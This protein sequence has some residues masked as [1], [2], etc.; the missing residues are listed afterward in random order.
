[1]K[2]FNERGQLQLG[3]DGETAKQMTNNTNILQFANDK[4]YLK[5]V[6]AAHNF[7]FYIALGAFGFTIYLSFTNAWWWFLIGFIGFVVLRGILTKSNEQNLL[8][9]L[10]NDRGLYDAMN[11][12]KRLS[13][14][15]DESLVDKLTRR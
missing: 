1:M 6:W 10:L 8:N 3:I 5:S 4:K 13:F 9:A 2:T 14:Q 7:W 15:I 11:S 12:A